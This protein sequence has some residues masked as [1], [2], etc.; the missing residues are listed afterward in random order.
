LETANHLFLG[1]DITRTIWRNSNWP[2]NVE[3]FVDLHISS[4]IKAI[5]NP[6]N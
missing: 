1:Y 4:W 2:L 3:A 6:S 5:V